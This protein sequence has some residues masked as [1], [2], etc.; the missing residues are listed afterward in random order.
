MRGAGVVHAAIGDRTITLGPDLG[1]I[2]VAQ[3]GTSPPLRM[4]A[5]IPTGTYN[6]AWSVTFA[7]GTGAQLRSVRVNATS[8]YVG[9]SPATVTLVVPELS[10]VAGFNDLWALAETAFIDW[11]VEV[12]STP[13]FGRQIPWQEGATFRTASRSGTFSHH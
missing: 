11:I 5:V 6:G 9:G 7:Q 10:T 12:Q 2:T 13:G 4:E 8:G 3:A 1:A